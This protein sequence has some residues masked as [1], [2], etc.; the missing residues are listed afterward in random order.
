MTAT[1]ASCDS[2]F[3]MTSDP[4][5]RHHHRHSNSFSSLA[6]SYSATDVESLYDE[7][8][9]ANTQQLLLRPLAI[10]ATS[11][12]EINLLTR[13]SFPQQQL[14]AQ[15]HRQGSLSS[16]S[17]L[18]T[19]SSHQGPP[20]LPTNLFLPD[21][22]LEASPTDTEFRRLQP[23]LLPPEDS[24]EDTE[25]QHYHHN[26]RSV[27]FSKRKSGPN[28]RVR[29]SRLS[30]RKGPTHRRISFDSLPTLEEMEGEFLRACSVQSNRKSLKGRKS[31]FC[32]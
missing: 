26:Q 20:M 10:L 24:D 12:P 25:N 5:H 6:S 28:H 23:R 1:V 4:Q 31:D 13:Q 22:A 27:S 29:K 8:E 32:S 3:S 19:C 15:H 9:R 21:F 7:F 11:S 2:S 14:H 30:Q 16:Q 17:S 18:S